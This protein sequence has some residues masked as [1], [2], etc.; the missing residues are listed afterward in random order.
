MDEKAVLD[1]SRFGAPGADLLRVLGVG[2]E[3]TD[4]PVQIQR[5]MYRTMILVRVLD[6]RMV[7]LQ[8]Q[9]RITF[10]VP[11]KGEEAAQVGSAAALQR[12]DWVFPAYREQGV[13]LYRGYPLEFLVAQ[14]YGNQEDYLKGRQ[15]PCHYG[16]PRIRFMCAS[17]VVG[18]QLPHAV[19][20]AWASQLRGE[21]A[22]SLVY[23]GDGVTSTGEF[24][25]GMNLAGVRRLPVVFFCKN[26]GWAISLPRE[27][28]TAAPT[29]A[30]KAA[31]YGFEGVRVDGNDLLAVYEATRQALE[32]ARGGGGPTMIEAVTYRMEAHSTSDDPRGYR[33]PALVEGWEARDPLLRMRAFL[34]ARERWSQDDEQAAWDEAEGRVQ[35]AIDRAESLPA[36]ELDTLCDDVFA[37]MP[38]H[39][40][41]Q[42]AEVRAAAEEPPP[43][44]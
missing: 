29:L 18:T 30:M 3:T 20:A 25:A 27:K 5:E 4:L 31:G 17:S 21:E 24:H 36:P 23:F 38:W 22:V 1:L 12:E 32:K 7:A 13:A 34:G 19:G 6:R 37:E 42:L 40:A 16:T 41:E 9:G 2:D 10:F 43:D 15:M 11:S 39:L 35:A 14:M 8:R 28:Q 26:N 33:D 44:A